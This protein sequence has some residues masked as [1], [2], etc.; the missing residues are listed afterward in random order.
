MATKRKLSARI[1]RFII[2]NSTAYFPGPMGVAVRRYLRARY[3]PRKKT[4]PK[5]VYISPH[6]EEAYLIPRIDL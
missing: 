2:F 5:F 4:A 1:A 3:M 6:I